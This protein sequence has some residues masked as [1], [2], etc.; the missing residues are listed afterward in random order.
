MKA[1]VFDIGNVLYAWDLKAIFSP[2][3][4]DP[5]ELDWF[6]NHV[7]TEEWHFQHDA[8]ASM[9]DTIPKLT[10]RYPQYRDLIARYD[11]DWMHSI[12]GEI[13]GMYDLVADLSKL[14]IPLYAIT[15]FSCDFFPRLR[16]KSRILPLFRDC[17]VSGCE[18]L[19]KP[20]PAIFTLGMKRF[21]LKKGEALFIDDKEENVASAVRC[22]Y[23]GHRFTDALT[24]RADMEKLCLHL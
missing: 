15:N 20:D 4:E 21:D 16:A 10:H 1:V 11:S 22:G 17:I 23:L 12:T 3:I 14:R 24:L 5:E 19:I 6:M 2:L 9:R 7:V 18:K 8:G 13:P